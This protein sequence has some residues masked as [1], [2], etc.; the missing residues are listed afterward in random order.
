[1]SLISP[2][3]IHLTRVVQRTRNTPMTLAAVVN[4]RALR[5]MVTA[6]GK[7]KGRYFGFCRFFQ[8]IVPRQGHVPTVQRSSDRST[9]VAALMAYYV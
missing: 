6:G 8:L 9:A 3:I 7:N 5:R 4:D 1:M 2:R